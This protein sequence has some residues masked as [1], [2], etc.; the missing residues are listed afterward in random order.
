MVRV[1]HCRLHCRNVSHAIA[2]E[3]RSTG[4]GEDDREAVREP[5]D[6]EADFQVELAQ[7]DATRGSRYGTV[8]I[9]AGMR[10]YWRDGGGACGGVKN[11][12]VSPLQPYGSTRR[13]VLCVRN[14]RAT[15]G[16]GWFPRGPS[17]CYEVVTYREYRGHAL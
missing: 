17:L 1:G 12:G 14:Y 3:D 5:G 11:V 2:N 4:N 10:G 7:Q 16:A 6:M 8:V 13:S 9:A 15:K